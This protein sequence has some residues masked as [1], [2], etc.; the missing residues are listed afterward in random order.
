MDGEGTRRALRALAFFI[1]QGN[2]RFKGEFFPSGSEVEHRISFLQSLT[3]SIS[4]M[5][6]DFG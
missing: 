1:L 3:T 4:E 2:C 6:P 5:L